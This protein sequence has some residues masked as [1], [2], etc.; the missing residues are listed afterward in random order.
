MKQK[1]SLVTV[2]MVSV[3]FAF[4][5]CKK[6][7]NPRCSGDKNLVI[8]TNIFATGLHNPRG[9]KFGP[10]GHLYVAEGGYGGKNISTNCQQPPPPVGPYMGSDTGSR[11][12][13][14]DMNG[15]RTTFV[16]HLPSCTGGPGTGSAITGMADVAFIGNTMYGLI[17]GAGCSHSVP[18]I[19]NSV[20]RINPDHTWTVAANYS[21]FLLSNP[22]AS[23]D[24]DD[25]TPDGNPYS[26]TVGNGNI[27]IA[28]PN[29]QEI[30]EVS[31]KT[32]E[33]KRIADISILHNGASDWI[34]PTTIVSHN[35]NLYFGTLTSFPLVQGAATVYKL[36]PNGT[37]T[38]YATG[39]TAIL[40]ILFD[41]NNN[42]YVLENTVGSPTPSPGSGDVVRVEPSGKRE[43]VTSGLHL[44]TAMTLGPDGK[45]YISDWGTG[46]IGLG[47]IV[48]VGFTCQYVGAD[49][50]AD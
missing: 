14:I 42:L 40:G 13:R 15:V 45:L 50:Q 41:Y 47:Q 9:L 37:Y 8:T 12:S 22:V 7:S 11:I 21:N 26:M 2:V 6:F 38:P 29:H 43:I 24:A 23:P 5:G 1:I 33:I 39:F 16:D 28:E 35:G 46:P 31:P 4:P 10:D 19:P 17:A 3:F 25:F 48:Q 49:T 30:D 32:G 36:L 27:Y 20:V 44:P 34:G 18:D